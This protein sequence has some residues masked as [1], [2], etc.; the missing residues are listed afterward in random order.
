MPPVLEEPQIQTNPQDRQS[1][2][3][4]P[5]ARLIVWLS[6]VLLIGAT[7]SGG[8]YLARKGFRGQ[9]RSR[10]VEEL[11]RRGVEASIGHLTLDPFRGLVARNVRIF[12]YKNRAETLAFISEIALDINY[13]AFF[14]HQPFLNALDIRNAE[15]T[16]PLKGQQGKKEWPQL[17]KF[18]AHI[19]F[20]PE[21]IYISQAEGIFCGIRISATGQLIK[22][23]DYQP[24][25]PLSEEEREKR[26]SIL[27]RIVAELQKFSFPGGPP[28]L[29]VK[30]NGDLAQLEDARA[31]ATLQG[32]LLKRKGYEMRDFI[33][34]A[35]WS[36][37]T[38]SMARCE[39]TDHFGGVTATATWSR[40]TNDGKF[41]ARSSLD[42]KTLL[43]AADMGEPLVE[44]TF[45][46]PPVIDVSGSANFAGARPRIKFIGHLAA[47]N[48]AYKNLPLSDC[49]AEFSW[50]G[51][52]TWI[53]DIHVRQ[54]VGELRAEVFEAPNEFRLNVDGPIAP[55]ALRPFVSPEIQE[56]LGEWEFSRPPVIQLA[57]QGKDRHPENWQGDGNISLDR[58]RFRGQWM[59]NA[60][61]KVHF[62]NGAVAYENF[63]IVR[64]E[65]VGTGTFV[66]DFA[67]HEVR[68]S[69]VKANVRPVEAAYW[70]DPDLPK[71][72]TPYKFHQP[73]AIT[74]NGVY[75]FRG[76]K[77]TKLE[78]TVDGPA[79]MDY[80]FL[81]KT[82]P[83]HKINAR[84]LFTNDRL[85]IVDLRGGLFSGTVR[86]SADISL[87]HNDQRYHAKLAVDGVDFPRLT[88]LYYNYKTAHGQLSGTYDFNGVGDKPRLMQGTGKITVAN[89]DVFVIPI[90]GPLSGIM[91]SL[92]PGT[93]A[94]YSVAHEGKASFAIKNGVLHA[95]DFEV[96]G[97]LFSM[98]G[99]GDVY[100][101]DDKLDF[102]I[103]I[104]PKGPG[105]LLTPVYKLFEYKGE[106]SLKNPNWHPKAF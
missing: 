29:Q 39:W 58:T 60:T 30:F 8:W 4:H 31:D 23:A 20:P 46:Q 47:D 9:W 96:A 66:Y 62:A 36:D 86:G 68:I 14:H 35:E 55:G 19:Y 21:Q 25:P 64:D 44:V 3:K 33:V 41:E 91:G 45:N 104:D 78:I 51:E 27:R 50:D 52:R 40:R 83:F 6:I 106:G 75:Q 11:H 71:T 65:G 100:F 61:S 2:S 73:P 49:R 48:L 85:Q 59:K 99:D 105:V 87:A 103:R 54:Q 5:L 26:W 88:D 7:I 67:N 53:R 17:R 28:S 16:L 34:A 102:N 84:L 89:G 22:R 74:A 10:V 92:L 76:G 77:G 12:S 101:L 24:S 93:R 69:N 97:K 80:V 79:G 95:D 70:I 90:F 1:T 32:T 98:L 38:L 63:R 72:V 15:V 43:D 81:G 94:G 57:I 18:H 56:F 82:L 37:Q 42:L 13:A